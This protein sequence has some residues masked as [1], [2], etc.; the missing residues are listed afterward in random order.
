MGQNK[1]YCPLI[2]LIVS[3]FARK[4]CSLLVAP[5]HKSADIGNF[6]T[7]EHVG[8]VCHLSKALLMCHGEAK[9]QTH[10]QAGRKLSPSSL[11]SPCHDIQ[12]KINR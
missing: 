3:L 6:Q 4:F 1:M 10:F 12:A 2:S 9:K 8:E 7:D 5:T 11:Q